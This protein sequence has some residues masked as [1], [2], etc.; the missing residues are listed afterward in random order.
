MRVLKV[1]PGIHWVEIPEAGLFILCG[2]PADSV[3][4][5]MKRGLIAKVEKDGVVFESGPNAILLSDVSLQNERF[6]N[7]A[8]FPVLQML[9]RQGMI[10]PGHPNNDGRKPL[11]IGLE[12]QIHD[13][14]EYIFRGNYG[15][16]SAEELMEAG[17]SE[18][19][20]R[21]MMRL[22]L[23]FAFERVRKTDDLIETRVV[24][25]DPV[26]LRNG[27]A[28][29]RIGLNVYEFSCN[30]EFVT[31][32]LNLSEN[33]DY[34]PPY[35]LGFN[36]IRREYF[37]VIHSG[38][39]DGW[40][41]GR[42][43]MS[44]ILVF[45]G[46]IYLIDAGPNMLAGLRALGIGVNE[47]EGI[48]HTHAH[49]DH[50]NGLAVLLRSDHRIKYYAVP[51]VRHS[52][53]KKLAALMPVGADRFPDFFEI[54]DLGEGTWNNIQ[55]LEVKP[56]FS[57][58][59]VETTVMYFRTLWNEGY[60]TYAH[61]A[62]IASFDVL[63]K[64]ITEDD[65][66]S[67]I[68]RH[69]YDEIIDT[70]HEPADIKKV[71]IGGGLIHGDAR[72]FSHDPSGKIILSHTEHALTN[73]QKEIGESA[74]FGMEDVLIPAEQDYTKR[75]AFAYLQQYFPDV[76][77]HELNMLLNCPV[78]TFNPGSMLVRYQEKNTYLFFI[79]SGVLEFIVHG[80]SISNTLTAGAIA[81][82]L[83]AL[84]ER[85]SS[86]TFRAISIVNALRISRSMYA[87]F[88]KRNS[89]FDHIL[90]NVNKRWFLQGT[91]LFGER[92]SCPAKST[93]AAAL[94][95]VKPAVG[96]DIVF[97]NGPGIYLVEAGKISLLSGDVIID[98]L[99]TGDFFGEES[100]FGN[101]DGHITARAGRDSILLFIPAG[102]LDGIPIV[103][104]KLF[105]TFERRMR[106]IDPSLGILATAT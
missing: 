9:Y 20:A 42:P 89:L 97:G 60:T 48:F 34:E 93:I 94:K 24:N 26:E 103:Q 70:Y 59:P 15:L 83:S 52:V 3:K 96:E 104:W 90:G 39:G 40:D 31:V 87:E 10:L 56:V 46:K 67:G 38:E 7:L 82:E 69:Y 86:G 71:D 78:Y 4:H 21:E 58:H 57:P 75:F 43:C 14:T 53:M 101:S 29:R 106:I 80:R 36:E 99:G 61:L 65:T 95:P 73:Q 74:S 91:W 45:Q 28:V 25:E 66:Q 32:D 35:Q 50:F 44:S 13:Q 92:L 1:S 17:A 33:E 88:L 100:I 64:M 62:D 41:A 49:D 27:S 72:D 63:K 11:L 47:I 6:A 76:P 79:L 85:P 68:S 102:K 37:S 98:T 18:T 55:G 81:G 84:A 77:L 5:L 30:G 19:L 12:Q 8:E 51:L 22:K 23:R 54:H 105:E 16:A 2:C